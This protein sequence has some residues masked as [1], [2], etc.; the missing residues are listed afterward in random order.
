MRHAEDIARIVEQESALVYARFDEDAAYRLGTALRERAASRA[1]PIV[2]DIQTWDRALYFAAM[3]GSTPANANWARRK[4]NA[5]ESF[6]KS[7][8][9]L[10]LERDTADGL[11]AP[12]DGLDAADYVF[13]GGGF[14]ITI[15]G[16]GVIGAVCVSGLPQRQDHELLVEALCGVLGRDHRAL[17]LRSNDGA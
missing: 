2:I 10:A 16:S 4:R 9:R 13:A 14:P 17:A 3:P 8:Y 1:M 15:E 5:V 11:P 7:T 12:R 6:R